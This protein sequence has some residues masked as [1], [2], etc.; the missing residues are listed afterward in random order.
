MGLLDKHGALERHSLLLT[1]GILIVVSIGGIIQ[2]GRQWRAFFEGKLAMHINKSVNNQGDRSG[3]LRGSE[4]RGCRLS[5]SHRRAGGVAP[6]PD[7]ACI[8]QRF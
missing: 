7:A 4:V 5:R 8:G 2:L 3:G 6:H 1:I